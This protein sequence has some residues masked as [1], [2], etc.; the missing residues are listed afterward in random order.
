M[1]QDAKNNDAITAYKPS[2]L[3]AIFGA[4]SYSQ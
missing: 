1:P 3:I 4:N 2:E